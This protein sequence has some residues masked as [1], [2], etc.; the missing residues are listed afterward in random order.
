ML[1]RYFHEQ[2]SQDVRRLVAACFVALPEGDSATVAGFYTLSAG[3][4]VLADL[5]EAVSRKLPRY[6]V[7][8]VAKVGRWAVDRRFERQQL[9]RALVWDAAK[10]A[11][12]LSV[13]AFALVVDA[14]DEAAAA[15]YRQQGFTPFGASELQLFIALASLKSRG[16]NPTVLRA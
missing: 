5:P 14:K 8:P 2:V 12:A 16:V 3:S 7:V 11:M 1:D 4:V 10:R 15:F 9:G 13:A 6:P